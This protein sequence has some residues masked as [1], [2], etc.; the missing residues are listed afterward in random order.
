MDLLD[1]ER[2]C[3]VHMLG[4]NSKDKGYR[5]HFAAGGDQIDCMERLREKGLVV[6]GI[7]KWELTFYHATELGCK[8]AGLNKKQTYK[9]LND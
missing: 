3:L 4:A 6:K 5:N 1:D 9:A 7:S 8:E 2:S